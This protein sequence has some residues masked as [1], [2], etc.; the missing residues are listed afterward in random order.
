MKKTSQTGY[1]SVKFSPAKVIIAVLS[2]LIFSIVVEGFVINEIP[3]GYMAANISDDDKPSEEVYKNIQVLKGTPASE[4]M[5]LMHFM[6]A[7]LNVK[8]NFCHVHDEKTNTWD[9]V[10]DTLEEKKVTREMI[11]MVKDINTRHFSGRTS[12]TCFTCHNGNEHP[13]RTPMLPQHIPVEQTEHHDE[14]LPE[15]KTII[16]NYYKAIGISGT[17]GIKTKYSSGSSVLYDGKSFPIEIYQQAPDK[18]LSI[19]TAPDGSKVYRGYDG[20]QGWTMNSEGIQPVD[21]ASLTTL[22]DFADIYSGV[23]LSKYSDTRVIGTDT[24]GG[25][26]CYVVWGVISDRKSSR[27][28]FDINTGLLL[29]KTIYTKTVIGSVPVRTEYSNYSQAGDVKAAYRMGYLFLDPRAEISRDFTAVKYNVSM[30]TVNFSMPV[31]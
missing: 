8:C 15:V 2:V 12:V 17:D 21:G 19:L 29:R 22:K 5:S 26:N 7:S 28:Y 31:K 30:D 13:Q 6:R 27:L 20:K 25:S 4:L 1:R 10:T 9:F 16:D 11:E 14:N 18:F 23:D 24:A 3:S